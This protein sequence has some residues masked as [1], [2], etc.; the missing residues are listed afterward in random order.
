MNCDVLNPASRATSDL[1]IMHSLRSAA[2]EIGFF[3][4]KA[5]ANDFPASL[6]LWHLILSGIPGGE[7]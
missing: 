5:C 1:A 4:V 3:G 6:V 7:S 2:L